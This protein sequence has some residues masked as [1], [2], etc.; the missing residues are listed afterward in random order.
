MSN[1]NTWRIK[2]ILQRAYLIL[3]NSISRLNPL[4]RISKYWAHVMSQK[5]QPN[6]RANSIPSILSSWAWLCGV[7]PGPNAA[8]VFLVGASRA[9][10]GASGLTVDRSKPRKDA[11]TPPLFS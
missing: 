4:G 8:E 2:I 7:R 3:S 11:L 9:A 5:S 10:S 6:C 1:K